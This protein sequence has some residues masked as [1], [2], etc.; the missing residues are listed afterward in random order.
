[1][2]QPILLI[3]L[4]VATMAMAQTPN[5][6]IE[7]KHI[8]VIG[9]AEME[10]IPDIIVVA[11]KLKEYQFKNQPKA[12]LETLQKEFLL[13][14]RQAEI[15]DSNISVSAFSGNTPWIM[16]RRKKDPEMMAE[17]NYEIRF[18]KFEQIEK[19]AALLN[20]NATSSFY[21]SYTTHSRIADYRKQVKTQAI[22]SAKEKA[23]Y[24]GEAIGERIGPALRIDEIPEQNLQAVQS[25][26]RQS[27]SVRVDD[28]GNEGS[29]GIRK[30]K[31]RYEIAAAFA[32]L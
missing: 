18:G 24:L 6:S 20:E 16:N 10:V 25:Y 19:L 7:Q 23:N 1:M 22:K 27:N 15:A 26:L 5:N 28:S 14:C 4:M 32:L 8:N 9:S 17:I 30:I 29:V 11:V 13:L 2:K 31:I 21:I 3:L 12:E